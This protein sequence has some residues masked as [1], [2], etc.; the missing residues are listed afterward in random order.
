MKNKNS[1]VNKNK[2]SETTKK[3]NQMSPSIRGKY[4]YEFANEYDPY[5]LYGADD[6]MRNKFNRYGAEFAQEKTA[7]MFAKR[8]SLSDRGF[9]ESQKQ[10]YQ[11]NLRQ[12]YNMEVGQ[13]FA[14]DRE[15]KNA[16]ERNK[17][18]EQNQRANQRKKD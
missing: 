8:N 3:A 12:N 18:Q 7:N 5:S 9:V 4:E 13:E 2:M 6:Q 14:N 15:L 11:N 10:K 17:T 1:D 16:R